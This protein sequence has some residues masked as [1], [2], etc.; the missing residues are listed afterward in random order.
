MDLTLLK[1]AGVVLLCGIRVASIHAADDPSLVKVQGQMEAA[2]QCYSHFATSDIIANRPTDRDWPEKLIAEQSKL[3][4]DL[5]KWARQPELL[6]ALIGHRDARV[7]TLV[8]G[9]LFVREDPHDLPLIGSLASDEAPTFVHVHATIRSQGFTGNLAD[10]EDPQTVGQVAEAMVATYLQATHVDDGLR[11][12]DYWQARKS[13]QTCASWF[14]VRINRAT[15]NISPQQPEY[16]NDV[17]RVISELEALPPAERAWTQVFLRCP[18]FP[19][20]EAT[21]TDATCVAALKEIG[22][23]EIVRFL[24]RQRVT[25]DPDLWFDDLET[26]NS[27]VY[28]WMAHFILRRAGELLRVDDAP[29]LLACEEFQR[30]TRSTRIGVSPFWAAAAAELI[31][32]RD[33]PAANQIIDDALGRYPLSDILGGQYQAVLI[34]SLWRINGQKQKQ[35]I[36]DWFYQAQAAVTQQKSDESNHGPADFLQSVRS[37]TRAD[38]KALMVELM[39]DPRFDQADWPSMKWLLAIAGDGL[40]EPLVSQQELYSIWPSR[41]DGRTLNVLAEWREKLKRHYSQ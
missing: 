15:R 32:Q 13:R 7:R 41:D 36:A 31:G 9:A 30:K 8:L 17:Q 26:H 37:A 18:S 27:R 20:V 4:A 39:A 5:Q 12:D 21:L 25:K 1:F 2:A 10:I 35:E 34:G 23:D 14:L 38:T 29:A 6:R 3:M 28:S 40:P 11:F 22:P 33:Q 24:Q 16:Q 19:D